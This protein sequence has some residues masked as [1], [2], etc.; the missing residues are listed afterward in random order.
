MS[1]EDLYSFDDVLIVVESEGLGYAVQH[2]MGEASINP[3][4]RKLRKLWKAA[5]EALEE[6][7]EYLGLSE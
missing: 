7:N 4:E 6:L 5:R 2:Y 1:E 3:K